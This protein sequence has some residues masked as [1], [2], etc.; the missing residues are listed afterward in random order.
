VFADG[1]QQFLVRFAL[2]GLPAGD[3]LQNLDKLPGFVFDVLA[4][5]LFLVPQRVVV[6]AS[7]LL[8]ADSTI[9]ESTHDLRLQWGW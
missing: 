2:S 3:V 6:V 7:L 4:A 8:G 5:A 9:R 1:A